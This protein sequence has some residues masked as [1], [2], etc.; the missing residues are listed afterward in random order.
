ME[1]PKE[2]EGRYF[3][4]FTHIDNMDSILKNGFICTNEKD[5]LGL[6]HTNVAS[7]SIQCRRGEMDVTCG[8]K[9]KVHDYV[10]FYMA[11]TNPMLLAVAHSKNVDQIDIVFF[12][13]PIEK[14]IE[15]SVVFTNASANTIVPPNF[16]DNPD[17][18]HHLNWDAIDSRKWGNI[19]N[20]WKHQRM[21]EVLVHGSVPL[22]WIE[23]IIVWNEGRRN[24]VNK[25]FDTY[26]VAKPK[27]TYSFLKGRYFYYTKFA[28]NRP[29]ETLITGPKQLAR[30]YLNIVNA[31][32]EKR[33]K[34][35][36]FKFKSIA[37]MISAIDKD[38]SAVEELEGIFELETINDFHQE[39]VSD[40]TLKVVA[41][42]KDNDYYNGLND[43]DKEI[44]KF[45]GYFHDIGKGPAGKWANGKQPAYPDHPADSLKLITRVLADDIEN[46]SDDAL[47]IIC[48]L[49]G[50]HDLLGDIVGHG[51]NISELFGI[52]DNER[53]LN[54]LIAL[55]IAD[56]EA[57][58]SD[59]CFNLELKLPDIV[60]KVKEKLE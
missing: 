7:E 8:P 21:A 33:K 58:N 45:A 12:A 24:L 1:I 3:Y 22:D 18:L 32:I 59:W 16:F 47:K 6:G 17:E 25:S 19:S 60:D 9:G 36:K 5:R 56:I 46:I 48:K 49:V 52:I 37:S 57:I 53:E 14:L 44:V 15:D 23:Y 43:C 51:R 10:P 55:S 41:N 11:S 27:I 13:I 34:R 31:I 26:E 4:H 2:H 40:H 28:L 54:M 42:L 50:Y 38:F 35:K 30:L 39:N 29:K 20:D